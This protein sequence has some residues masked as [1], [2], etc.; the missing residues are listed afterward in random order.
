MFLSELRQNDQTLVCVLRL[1]SLLDET[2]ERLAN[3]SSAESCGP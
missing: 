2:E 3:N 1:K